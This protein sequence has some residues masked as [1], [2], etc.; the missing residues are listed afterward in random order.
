MVAG[1]PFF[2]VHKQARCMRASMMKGMKGSMLPRCCACRT[3]GE[4]TASQMGDGREEDY[5]QRL[6]QASV[7]MAMLEAKDPH[8]AHLYAWLYHT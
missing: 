7:A 2:G 4:I 3:L 5:V 1:T 6:S 8:I